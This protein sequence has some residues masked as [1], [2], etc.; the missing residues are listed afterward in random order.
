MIVMNVTGWWNNLNSIE[1]VFWGIAIVFTTLFL[2]Q[3]VMS[4]V[5]FSTDTEVHDS[6]VSDSH[7]DVE[8]HLF[9]FRSIIAFFTFFGWVGIIVYHRT[10][11]LWMATFFALVSGVIAMATVAYVMYLLYKMEEEGNLR[12]EETLGAQGEVYLPIPGE[13]AGSGKILVNI[14]GSLKELDARTLGSGLSTGHKV[15]VVDVLDKQEVLVVSDE[16]L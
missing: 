10:D 3:L 13:N 12:M 8:F 7:F 1:Q 15:K 6:V 2:I 9:S 16:I 5:G 14:N 4:I 11:Q